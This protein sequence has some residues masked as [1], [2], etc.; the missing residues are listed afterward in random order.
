MKLPFFT[1]RTNKE[2]AIQPENL[3]DFNNALDFITGQDAASFSCIDLIA[4]NFSKLSYG[5]YERGTK[6]PV[7]N[8]WL[9]QLISRPNIDETHTLFFDMII[10]D[11]YNGGAFLYLYKNASGKVVSFFRM[12][13]SAVVVRRG[14]FNRKEYIYN[15]NVYYSDRVLHIPSK[16]GYNGLEGRAIYSVMG[17]VFDTALQLDNYVKNT[18]GQNLGKRLVIDATDAYKELTDKEKE[19]VENKYINKYG[20]VQNAGR[21]IVKTGGVKFET[22]DTGTNSNQASELSINREYQTKLSCAL[23]HVPHSMVTG[24]LPADT[25]S[26][27]SA[28]ASEAVEPVAVIFQEY[29][30]TLLSPEEQSRYYFE[31]SYNSLLKTSLTKRVEAYSKELNN[32]IL[33]VDEIRQKENLP[34]L[35]TDAANTHFVPANNMPLRDDVMDAYMASAKEK[36]ANIN[37]SGKDTDAPGM[38]DD[39][40]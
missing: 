17:E 15:G 14:D 28:F 29:F 25:E 16:F 10:R 9:Y 32:G 22:I 13:P 34:I 30:N 12:D 38:G 1:K 23:Y 40:K 6:K 24:D 18:F 4:N 36:Q 7:Q 20:G 19:I 2:A 39:K 5:V 11:W 31:F 3:R 37:N 8:H 26:I 33:S 21:P 35:G 27:F